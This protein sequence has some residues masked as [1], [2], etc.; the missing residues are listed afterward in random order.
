MIKKRSVENVCRIFFG[1]YIMKIRVAVFNTSIPCVYY[2]GIMRCALGF[3]S[4]PIRD[5]VVVSASRGE[6]S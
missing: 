4:R 1:Y 2:F 5:E 3:W 6:T